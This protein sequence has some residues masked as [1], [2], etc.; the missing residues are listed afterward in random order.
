[1]FF[2]SQSFLFS[3]LILSFLYLLFPCYFT[4][5]F[6]PTLSLS[7]VPLSCFHLS[8]LTLSFLLSFFLIRPFHLSF[9]F[10]FLVLFSYFFKALMNLNT[11][12]SS[13]PSFVFHPS[14]LPIH[15]P[16]CLSFI[17]ILSFFLSFHHLFF[18]ST[19]SFFPF[20]QL[21]DKN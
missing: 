11:F 19:P 4:L 7:F 21:I 9:L 17:Y 8:L 6:S 15:S 14:I 20:W 3:L 18:T 5:S 16:F 13:P 1:M 12:S 2:T 10:S